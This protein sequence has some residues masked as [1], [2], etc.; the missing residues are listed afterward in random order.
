MHSPNLFREVKECLNDR[1]SFLGDCRI[2]VPLPRWLVSMEART[3]FSVRWIHAPEGIRSVRIPD[4]VWRFGIRLGRRFSA[5]VDHAHQDQRFV[6]AVLLASCVFG[7]LSD[8]GIHH[9]QGDP[10]DDLR[11]GVCGMDHLPWIRVAL[12]GRTEVRQHVTQ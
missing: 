5:A 4:R 8:M 12:V 9:V 11:S 1:T 3:D 2:G 7:R 6:A 10:H